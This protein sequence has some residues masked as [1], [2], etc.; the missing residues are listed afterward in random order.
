MKLFIDA[1]RN[2]A[3]EGWKLVRRGESAIWLLCNRMDGLDND[4]THLC[5]CLDICP[6]RMNG[7][8]VLVWILRRVQQTDWIP[9]EIQI[10]EKPGTVEHHQMSSAR[11]NIL[12]AYRDREKFKAVF[13]QG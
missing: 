5:L 3:P 9:P 4:I 6:G 1:A 8:E 7:L 13:P 12:K 11:G 2:F 10:R